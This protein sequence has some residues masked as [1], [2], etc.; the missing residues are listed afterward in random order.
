MQKK[1]KICPEFKYELKFNAIYLRDFQQN[2]TPLLTN[3]A[4]KVTW[5]LGRPDGTDFGQFA[6]QSFNVVDNR[7]KQYGPFSF[8]IV[9]SGP[10]VTKVKGDYFIDLWAVI[11]CGGGI[12]GAIAVN[13]VEVNQVGLV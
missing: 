12:A 7:L 13:G 9:K 10:G 4:C 8:N 5:G 11:S 2:G 3:A 6:S 1:V